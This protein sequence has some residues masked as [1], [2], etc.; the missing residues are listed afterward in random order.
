MPVGSL[1]G[2]GQ[3]TRLRPVSAEVTPGPESGPGQ[4]ERVHQQVNCWPG[5]SRGSLPFP[6]ETRGLSSGRGCRGPGHES[7]TALSRPAEPQASLPRG[8]ASHRAA[9]A[10]SCPRDPSRTQWGHGQAEDGL[11]ACSCSWGPGSFILL[12]YFPIFFFLR[13]GELC[14]SN[15]CGREQ[16]EEVAV[17]PEDGVMHGPPW[18]WVP[19]R[20]LSQNKLCVLGPLSPVLMCHDH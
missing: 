1:R 20:C 18:L 3:E 6:V 13:V 2:G 10:P 17:C 7:P 5:P 15:A 12:D 14:A 16:G 4:E 8:P 11:P 19:S 9:G